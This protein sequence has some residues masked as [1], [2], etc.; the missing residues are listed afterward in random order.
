[1]F[2]WNVMQRKVYLEKCKH[3]STLICVSVTLVGTFEIVTAG[4]PSPQ[5]R[6]SR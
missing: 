2:L 6:S 3:S 4:H 5:G 1:M